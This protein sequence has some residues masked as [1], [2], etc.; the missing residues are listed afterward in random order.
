MKH[1]RNEKDYG[2]YLCPTKKMEVTGPKLLKSMPAHKGKN[3][4]I[5]NRSWTQISEMQQ[6]SLSV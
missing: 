3:N 4:L 6:M 1:I 2:I 5:F